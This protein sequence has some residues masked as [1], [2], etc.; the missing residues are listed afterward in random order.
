MKKFYIKIKNMLFKKKTIDLIITKDVLKALDD[1][2][3]KLNVLDNLLKTK[4]ETNI[5]TNQ[6]NIKQ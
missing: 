1:V 2:I 6:K 5:Q 3:E 4:D